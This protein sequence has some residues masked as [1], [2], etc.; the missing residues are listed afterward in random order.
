MSIPQP[1]DHEYIL[2]KMRV[3]CNYQERCIQDVQRKLQSW[4]VTE[5]VSGEII[6]ALEKEGLV[7]EE[8]FARVYAGSKFRLNK[9]GRNRIAYELRKKNIPG[10]YIQIGLR[11]IDDEEYIEA[12]KQIISRKSFSLKED[13]ATRMKNKLAAYAVSR[14]YETSLVLDVLNE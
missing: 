4:N 5:K 10:L 2:N 8:R 11:E 1:A 12:L 9:W 14:G 13:N 6:L 7:D 3:F